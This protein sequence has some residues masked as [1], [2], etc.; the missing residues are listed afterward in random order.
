MLGSSGKGRPTTPFGK[1]QQPLTTARPRP[2]RQKCNMSSQPLVDAYAAELRE[3]LQFVGL[4]PNALASTLETVALL[5]DIGKPRENKDRTTIHPL[6]GKTVPRRHPVVGAVAAL[7][8]VPESDDSRGL[9]ASLVAK[10]STGWSWY[11]NWTKSGQQP[12]DKAW[13]R[14]DQSIEHSRDGVGL[15]LLALFKMADIDGHDDLSDVVWF[16]Q[17]ANRGALSRWKMTL[18]LP[19]VETL[20]ELQRAAFEGRGM[21]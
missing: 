16:V 17:R 4:A 11:R 1:R 6:T 20:G 12:S 15:L 14:L 5:H 3:T 13:N 21:S 7:E 18:P 2:R 8:L 9:I 19:T 10:H